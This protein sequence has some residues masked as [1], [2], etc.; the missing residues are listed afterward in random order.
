LLQ[1]QVQILPALSKVFIRMEKANVAGRFGRFMKARREELGLT[2]RSLARKLGVEGSFIAYIESGRR[3]PSLALTGKIADA[4]RLDRQEVFLRAHTEARALVDVTAPKPR[5]KNSWSW[6]RF[7]RDHELLS[8]AHVTERERQ[9]L[10]HLSVLGTV[11]ST[12][13]SSRF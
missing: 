7:M 13:P 12:K 6:D 4:L 2:Q 8:R 11:S 1:R 3:R 5:K 10:E 9:A